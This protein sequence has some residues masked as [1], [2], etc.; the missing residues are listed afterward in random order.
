MAD[1]Y[2]TP[3]Q[4]QPRRMSM[5][6]LGLPGN[7]RGKID[8]GV[9]RT[10]GMP[11][12]KYRLPGLMDNPPIGK[13]IYGPQELTPSVGGPGAGLYHPA[14]PTGPHPMLQQISNP[15]APPAMPQAPPQKPWWQRDLFTADDHMPQPEMK[16]PPVPKMWPQ[17]ATD[18]MK[19]RFGISSAWDLW[20]RAA[21]F[22]RAAAD[23]LQSK[24]GITVPEEIVQNIPSSL[25][26]PRTASQ[27][28]PTVQ[29]PQSAP[30]APPTPQTRTSNVWG[31]PLGDQFK[32]LRGPLITNPPDDNG[33]GYQPFD[34]PFDPNFNPPAHL[35]HTATMP[36]RNDAMT[37]QAAGQYVDSTLGENQR[38][39]QSKWNAVRQN[40][41]FSPIDSSVGAQGLNPTPRSALYP[42]S[43]FVGDWQRKAQ[44]LEAVPRV[45]PLDNGM[46]NEEILARVRSGEIPSNLIPQKAG[47]TPEEAKAHSDKMFARNKEQ[48]AISASRRAENATRDFETQKLAL[49]RRNEL[50]QL[51]GPRRDMGESWIQS[52]FRQENP[53]L[54]ARGV[55]SDM[56]KYS[57]AMN[58]RQRMDAPNLGGYSPQDA[59]LLRQ[60]M[61]FDNAAGM[62][63]A[64][65]AEARQMLG[66]QLPQG[67]SPSSVYPASPGGQSKG[68]WLHPLNPLSQAWRYLFGG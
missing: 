24:L 12:K 29:Q 40:R 41:G 36:Y 37:P 2:G 46:S 55:N 33:P 17:A 64:Q 67:Q 44:G 45:E 39:M 65:R 14:P 50:R 19:N 34:G 48:W 57:A 20:P 68:N 66:L 13:P 23:N 1:L 5:L 56:L 49:Q 61:Y 21:K 52:Q 3:P 11:P 15:V 6:G 26:P 22:P 7:S 27:P 32:H 42:Q 51:S 18:T 62:N 10:V 63:D 38:Y 43:S 9:R 54:F 30:A 58:A 16:I 60:K 35:R 59:Q 31:M 47:M 4:I 53:A 28:Q 25:P 8:D